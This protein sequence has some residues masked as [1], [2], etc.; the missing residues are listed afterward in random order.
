MN[1]I[2]LFANFGDW[3]KVPYG[4]GEVG[5]RRTLSFLQ[6]GNW[7]VV[8]IP[9]YLRVRN[10]SVINL[11][12]LGGKIV[13]N[14]L[15]YFLFLSFGTRRNSFVHIAGFYGP[16]IYFEYA[17]IALGKLLGYRVIYEMRGGGADTYFKE[18]SDSYKRYFRKSL[19]KCNVVFTQG[20]EN[21][22]LIKE[23]NST[24]DIFYYPNCVTQ[25][26]YPTQYPEKPKDR[27]NLFYFGRI[28]RTKNVD[29]V[30]DA[31]IELKSQFDNVYL[32]I[33]G[34]CND[35]GYM[36]GINHK[37]AQNHLETY[38]KIHPACNHEMLKAHLRD[39][40]FYIFPTTEPHEG[41]SNALTEAMAWG[42]I[43]VAT[44]Q[45]FNRSVISDDYLI[46]H[47]LSGKDFAEII[48]DIIKNKKIEDYSHKM[49]KRVMEN[50]TDQTVC[51]RLLKE[52]GTLFERYA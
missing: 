12:R 5:N 35:D 17:L 37:I 26:F 2:Y 6:K 29:V 22:S 52:Y 25:D 18:G 41:H 43:P 15:K 51:E 7:D 31:F 47:K 50:Y 10:H 27:I 30:I 9:K 13:G 8:V 19:L 20:M 49:Y 40:H 44:S 1:K 36:V 38:I 34:N 3:N 16:M 46:V 48:A 11:I 33:V 32:D 42:L 14:V 24:V 28:S 45:G 21:I 39:K 4:G 23:I